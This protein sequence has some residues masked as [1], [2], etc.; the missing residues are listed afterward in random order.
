M[1]WIAYG[2]LGG[3]NPDRQP[4]RAGGQVVTSEGSLAADI[5]LTGPIER[6]WMGRNDQ[7]VSQTAN[8]GWER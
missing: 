1:A 2:E 3:V 6:Q 4:A 8:Q 7:T 5:E